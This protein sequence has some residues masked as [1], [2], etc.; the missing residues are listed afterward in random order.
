MSY[1]DC[2]EQITKTV[3]DIKFLKKLKKDVDPASCMSIGVRR[4]V[5]QDNEDADSDEY[6]RPWR[7]FSFSG[8]DSHSTERRGVGGM[9]DLIDILIADRVK[10]LKFW[11]HQGAMETQKICQADADA[12]QLLKE[13]K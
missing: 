4:G 1:N 11:I 3:E 7:Q 2:A 10:S 8:H 12:Q 5:P 6:K 9:H 13:M